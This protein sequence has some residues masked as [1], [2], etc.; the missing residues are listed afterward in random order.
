MPEHGK[1]S[2]ERAPLLSAQPTTVDASNEIVDDDVKE[3]SAR[4]ITVTRGTLCVLAMGC[5]I[6]LQATNI[7]LLTTTQSA[8]AAELDAFEKTSWFT[9]AYLVSLHPQSQ[10]R[11]YLTKACS[12]CHVQHFATG[13]KTGSAVFP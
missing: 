13:R 12:D 4:G 6:F 5:L 8:I 10:W 11:R 3:D 7:S 2:D 1:P 9:S